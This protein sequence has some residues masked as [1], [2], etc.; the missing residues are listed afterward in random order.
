[1]ATNKRFSVRH[2]L[3]I[4][5]DLEAGGS[6]GTSGQ[7]LSSTGTGVQW[8]TPSG[9]G[10]SID[11]SGSANKLAIW[12]DS[13]TLTFDTNLHWDTTN[14]RLGINNT[15]PS[16]SLDLTGDARFSGS[17][18]LANTSPTSQSGLILTRTASSAATY[19]SIDLTT[20]QTATGNYLDRLVNM[21]KTISA[22]GNVNFVRNMSVTN[23]VNSGANVSSV[24]YGNEVNFTYNGSGAN[25]YPIA[26]ATTVGTG[27]SVTNLSGFSMFI[28]TTGT[29][30]TI[31]TIRASW[32]RALLS[33]STAS[34]TESRG[35]TFEQ[36]SKTSGASFTNNYLIYA[37]TTVA[38]ATNN[39]TLYM[40]PNIPAYHV[41]KV[42]IGSGV[43]A[44]TARLQVRDT[45]E[46]MRLEY[47]A[48]NYFTTSVGT[49]GTVTIDAVGSGA[50]FV[51]SDAVEVPDSAYDSG[52]DGSTAVPTRNAVY[53]RLEQMKTESFIIAASDEITSITAGTNKVKFRM[54]YA[55]TVTA[56]R[57]SLSTAQTS[58]NIFTVDINESGTSI[59]STKLTIDNTE[60]TSTTAATAPVISDSALADDAEIS[61]D[62]DQI[63]DGT[64]KGL[65]ITIIGFRP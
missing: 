58:G 57:A 56:V 42:G 28:S 25:S 44:P 49:T 38:Q 15:S 1:M 8:I 20:T 53:D 45:V 52:W 50:K 65:K 39:Y 4:N 17:L 22:S 27:G 35:V 2:G 46:Q 59:L 3:Q 34:V 32:I 36:W 41:G 18:G 10:G 55:F 62:V 63:G 48:S 40:L 6:T 13:D 12:S 23:T 64:A 19:N 61:V 54:P 37:D 31:G 29:S 30:P 33:S 51:F 7:V 5:G 14:D 60:T 43:T 47:D 9:G 11:G 24:H 16:F 26:L 21:T